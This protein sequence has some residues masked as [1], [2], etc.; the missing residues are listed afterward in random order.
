MD[1]VTCYVVMKQNNR[2][3]KQHSSS[4]PANSTGTGNT[5]GHSPNSPQSTH[6]PGD[7]MTTAS[8]LQHVNNAPKSMMIYGA[9]GTGGIAATTNQLVSLGFHLCFSYWFLTTITFFDMYYRI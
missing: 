8:S 1:N 3:R 5:V 7:G 9:E 6:T 4:G 2:K